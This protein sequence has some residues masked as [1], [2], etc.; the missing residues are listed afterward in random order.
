MPLFRVA[1]PATPPQHL[2]AYVV[3]LDPA[4]NALLLVGSSLSWTVAPQWWS[5]R[6]GCTSEATVQRE[7]CEELQLPA[8]LLFPHPLFLTVTQTVGTTAGHTDVSLWYVVCGDRQ[9]SLQ[10]DQAEFRQIAWFALDH[11]PLERSDPHLGRF[12]AKLRRA[13]RPR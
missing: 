11:L 8:Q 6:A 12:V 9:Q 4:A 13:L 2:V 10:Y 1:K 7:L 3:L 5:H